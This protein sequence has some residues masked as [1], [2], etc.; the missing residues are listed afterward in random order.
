MT[1]T[2]SGFARPIRDFLGAPLDFG[3]PPALLLT[4]TTNVVLSAPRKGSECVPCLPRAHPSESRADCRWPRLRSSRPVVD[5]FAASKSALRTF[6]TSARAERVVSASPVS[7]AKEVPVSRAF[8]PTSALDPVAL[9]STPS[10]W[11]PWRCP[12]R[13]DERL[14]CC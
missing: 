2:D 12:A 8:P 1:G 3:S 4:P 7:R 13:A 14:D 10:D 9:E 11:P 5:R 6:A